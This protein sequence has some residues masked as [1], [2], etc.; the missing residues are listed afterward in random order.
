MYVLLW[1]G[2]QMSP[3]ISAACDSP[4]NTKPTKWPQT[5]HSQTE[6]GFQGF[7]F[8]INLS[9]GVWQLDKTTKPNELWI[10][11][12]CYC[13]IEEKNYVKSNADP[14]FLKLVMWS[15]YRIHFFYNIFAWF[16]MHMG[17]N[18]SS[19]WLNS[20]SACWKPNFEH[21]IP[22]TLTFN[23]TYVPHRNRASKEQQAF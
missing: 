6:D 5:P 1:A 19:N 17:F 15:M 8:V 10:N 2:C 22:V 4:A 13:L 23:D 11:L 18:N 7:S 16:E 21:S 9:S 12:F 14:K 3:D 20:N